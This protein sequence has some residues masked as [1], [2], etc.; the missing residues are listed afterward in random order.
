MREPH[1]LRSIG[2]FFQSEFEFSSYWAGTPANLCYPYN[3]LLPGLIPSARHVAFLPKLPPNALFRRRLCRGGL[4]FEDGRDG[5]VAFLPRHPSP[6]GRDDVA[7]AVAE[8][9]RQEQGDEQDGEGVGQGVDEPR[10]RG[11]RLRPYLMAFSP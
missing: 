3:D 10:R 2:A 7:D 4:V 6:D 8:G 1:C 11:R 9:Q 5:S